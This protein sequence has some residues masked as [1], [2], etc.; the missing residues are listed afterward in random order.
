MAYIG[1]SD[2]AS[3]A[4]LLCLALED[5]LVRLNPVYRVGSPASAKNRVGTAASLRNTPSSSIGPHFQGSTPGAS[6]RNTDAAHAR[7]PTPDHFI[8]L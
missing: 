7:R 1:C 2:T 8:E 3:V 5:H 4:P 6:T